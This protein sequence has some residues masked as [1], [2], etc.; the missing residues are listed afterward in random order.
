MQAIV[1]GRWRLKFVGHEH[2]GM[3]TASNVGGHNVSHL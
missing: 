3:L 1:S 2:V